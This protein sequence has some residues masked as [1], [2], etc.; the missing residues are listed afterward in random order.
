MARQVSPMFQGFQF[1]KTILIWFE[2]HPGSAGWMQAIVAGVAIIAV[3]LAATIPV[4]AEARFRAADRRLRAE[5]MA[6]LLLPEIIVLKGEIE[7]HIEEG[8]VYDIPVAVPTSLSSKTDEL[9]LLGETGGRLLQ[10]VGM[11]NGVAAQTRRYQAIGML[12]GAPVLSKSGIGLG[13]WRNNVK[14]LGLCLMNLDEAI[15]QIQKLIGPD[16]V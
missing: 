3:Y 2:A 9:Y 5:G 8:S 13:I 14:S 1:P 12:E 4:R 11:V 10:A 16:K 6:L 7:T 15:E